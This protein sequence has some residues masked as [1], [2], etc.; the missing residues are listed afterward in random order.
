MSSKR[1]HT[2]HDFSRH[3][4][5]IEV[6]C[7]CGHVAVLN[8]PKVLMLFHRKRWPIGIETAAKRFRCGECGQRAVRL[9]PQ[10]RG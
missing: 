6:A 8:T 3:G 4:Y 1:F 5:D 2:V 9:G 7:G 10:N